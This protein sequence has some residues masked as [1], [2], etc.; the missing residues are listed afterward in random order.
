MRPKPSSLVEVEIEP[1]WSAIDKETF[2]K[3]CIDYADQKPKFNQQKKLLE[4][5]NLYHRKEGKSDYYSKYID[6]LKDKDIDFI[7]TYFMVYSEVE[8]RIE[9]LLLSEGI[10]I[11]EESRRNHTLDIARNAKKKDLKPFLSGRLLEDEDYI[12]GEDGLSEVWVTRIQQLDDMQGIDLTDVEQMD[13]YIVI[14]NFLFCL[15][16]LIY[17][18]D[19]SWYPQRKKT[20]DYFLNKEQY[21]REAREREAAK[22]KQNILNKEAWDAENE[23]NY[24]ESILD[25]QYSTDYVI[26]D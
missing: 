6:L 24:I 3:K 15:D 21:I 13:M 7:K 11:E 2:K 4:N 23:Q 22:A 1:D 26:E 25:E 12:L 19:D 16:M 14:D 9:Q 17:E 10:I 20:M 5:L 18:R 8:Y